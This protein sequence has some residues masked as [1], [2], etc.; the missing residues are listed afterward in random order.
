M[1][2][3]VCRRA[4]LLLAVTCSLLLTGLAFSNASAQQ[5]GT[6]TGNVTS[7]DGRA[8][9]G[10][11]VFIAGLD[12]GGL[13]N[14]QGQFLLQNVPAG[15][16]ALSVDRLG[17]QSS[18]QSVDVTS[19]GVVV[20]D[21]QMVE[22]AINMEGIVVTGVAAATPQSQLAFTVE[23]MDVAELQRIPVPSIRGLLQAK[24]PGVKV[25]QGSGQ[26]GSEPSL[27]FRGPTSIMGG[28]APLI[29]VDGVIT[30]GGIADLNTQDIASMEIVKGAAAAALYG[31][32]AQAG[33]LQ[34]TTKSGAGMAVGQSQ[35]TVRTTIEQNNLEHTLG[36]NRHHPYRMDASGNF[37][38]SSGNIVTL[39]DRGTNIALDD[40]GDGTDGA[41]AFADQDFP[42][43][44]FDPLRQFFDPGRRL[45]TNLAVSGNSQGTQYFISGAYTREEG[46]I[47]L[48]DPMTQLSL[49]MNLTQPV[50]DDLSLRLTSYFSDRKRDLV[51]EQGSFVR[52]LTFSTAFADLLVPD[53]DEPGGISHIGEPIDNGNVGVNPVNRLINT[54]ITED[55][56]RFIGASTPTTLPPHGSR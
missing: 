24:V 20:V 44:T 36:M 40:G 31:S 30:Q 47:S 2:V 14:A 55:R 10:A 42:G 53:P 39:P 3:A 32:R 5:V 35:V 52:A 18:T 6:V 22:R 9:S 51:D 1:F 7:T 33:V 23:R 16:H 41:S 54:F 43:Q 8:L 25:I 15:Q 27:Q 4:P 48:K 56:W 49:R 29:V 26:A 46:A 45:T 13:T 37:L 17:Y 38:N 28:Q 21:F 50:A 11:Q 34:I 12:I 19:G